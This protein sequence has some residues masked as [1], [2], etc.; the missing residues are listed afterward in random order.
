MYK[1]L[2]ACWHRK[3]YRVLIFGGVVAALAALCS[4]VALA[5]PKSA[6]ARPLILE[7]TTWHTLDTQP[8]S[9]PFG[10]ITYTGSVKLQELVSYPN[11]LTY[12][13]A[14]R[15]VATLTTPSGAN[16]NAYVYA[17]LLYDLNKPTTCDPTKRWAVNG[18]TVTSYAPSSSGKSTACGQAY[19]QYKWPDRST[20]KPYNTA[21]FRCP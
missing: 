21:T 15:A 11:D 12:C 13:G 4:P 18:M 20:E 17:C 9:H 6:A 3:S 1:T 2:F 7:C 19:G 14:M 5:A 8:V 16:L 10:V